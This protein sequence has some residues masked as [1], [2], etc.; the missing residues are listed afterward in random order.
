[1]RWG[2]SGC[3]SLPL[4]RSGDEVFIRRDKYSTHEVSSRQK[5]G[6]TSKKADLPATDLHGNEDRI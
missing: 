6:K 1:M 3:Y 5:I 2:E 4:M